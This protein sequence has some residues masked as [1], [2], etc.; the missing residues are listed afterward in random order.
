MLAK[1]IAEFFFTIRLNSMLQKP[2]WQLTLRFPA[3]S[4]RDTLKMKG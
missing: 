1:V 4:I 2:D 3:Y